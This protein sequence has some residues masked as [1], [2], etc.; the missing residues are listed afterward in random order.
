MGKPLDALFKDMDKVVDK[1]LADIDSIGFKSKKKLSPYI[2]TLI[3]KIEALE[4]ELG[5]LKV[6]CTKDQ[7]ANLAYVMKRIKEEQSKEINNEVAK[8]RGSEVEL[9]NSHE[10]KK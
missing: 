1:F 9:N 2:K 6:I 7:L 5:E 8:E 3:D 10:E 4:S